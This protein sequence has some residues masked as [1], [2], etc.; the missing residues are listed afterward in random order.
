M[1]PEQ[2]FGNTR[3]A[4]GPP[5]DVYALGGLLY[6]ALTG[7]APFTGD[8]VT[9]IL[10]K[11]VQEPPTPVRQVRPSVP[12]ELEAVCLRCLC[13]E[14]AGRYPSAGAVA[15]ALRPWASPAAASGEALAPVDLA[16]SQPH[17]P[18]L[19]PVAAAA[20]PVSLP[21]RRRRFPVA[22]AGAVVA[23]VALALAVGLFL[24]HHRP[25]AA[26]ALAA[27][28]KSADASEAAPPPDF[29]GAPGRPPRHD[30]GAR[31][32]LVG[33]AAGPGGELVLEEGRDIFLRVEVERDA[34]VGIW[35][36][37]PD[38]AVVQLFPNEH[39]AEHRVLASEPRT[40]P[41]KNRGYTIDAVVSSGREWLLVVASTRRWT[42]ID[43]AKRGPFAVFRGDEDRD[44]WKDQLR[45]LV[46]RP[47]QVQAQAAPPAVTEITIPYRVRR[48]GS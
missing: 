21:P 39:E 6:F 44:R 31:L 41:G 38:Q 34:Y 46:L 32:E 40:I 22:R 3:G 12:A 26:P 2:A 23:A 48:R 35:T 7:A 18:E 25:R 1:A 36:V 20:L 10:F 13:K 30:F 42:P 47:A 14:P 29:V 8:S 5:A 15:E 33:S 4:V 45:G 17:P 19:R 37:D 28:E 24:A 11:V 43:G 9:E 27:S 16:V